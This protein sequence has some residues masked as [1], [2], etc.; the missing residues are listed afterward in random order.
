MGKNSVNP[1]KT[2]S[3]NIVIIGMVMGM[4]LFHPAAMDWFVLQKNKCVES[5]TSC[6]QLSCNNGETCNSFISDDGNT[7]YACQRK[8]DLGEGCFN[9][10]D[11]S[12]FGDVNNHESLDKNS[13]FCVDANRS[14]KRKCA[15][16][17]ICA[18]NS[19]CIDDEVC[20]LRRL[21]S[22]PPV[23]NN[24][25]NQ[26]GRKSLRNERCDEDY[27]CRN[28]NQVCSSNLCKTSLLLILHVSLI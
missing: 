8:A 18:E 28:D 10:S 1:T 23:N 5:Y 27:D 16:F 22:Y 14:V 11:C 20:I 17:N 21:V 4:V 9:N 2:I 15:S 3:G 7:Y 25:I 19:D 6:E 26:C 12:N 13:V 24:L